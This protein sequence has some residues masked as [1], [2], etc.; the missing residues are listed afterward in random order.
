MMGNNTYNKGEFFSNKK[1]GNSIQ[2]LNAAGSYLLYDNN[3]NNF[4][5]R[6]VILFTV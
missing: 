4:I 5:L 1:A 2:I 3:Y 6:F